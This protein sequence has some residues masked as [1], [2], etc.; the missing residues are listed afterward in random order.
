MKQE[1]AAYA[2]SQARG[3]RIMYHDWKRVHGHDTDEGDMEDEQDC[4]PT[5]EI[6]DSLDAAD[7]LSAM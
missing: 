3:F 2:Y 6:Q 1:W 5:L 4:P 7:A